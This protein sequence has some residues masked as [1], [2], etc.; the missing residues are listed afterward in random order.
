MM[1]YTRI[2]ISNIYINN[3]SAHNNTYVYDIQKKI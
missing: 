3:N 1:V 2:L